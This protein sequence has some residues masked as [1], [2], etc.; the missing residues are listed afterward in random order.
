MYEDNRSMFA[1]PYG[2]SAL[3]RPTRKNPRQFPCPTCKRK[4]VL[5]AEDK[6]RGYQC[7]TCADNDE[8]GY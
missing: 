6:R 4:N 8:G 3:R 2:K 5:T 7:D 1:D